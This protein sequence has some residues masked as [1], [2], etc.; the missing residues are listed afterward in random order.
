M[1]SA[2]QVFCSSVTA[3]KSGVNFYHSLQGR[4]SAAGET[5]SRAS[6]IRE[7]AEQRNLRASWEP[8]CL[9]PRLVEVIPYRIPQSI[10]RSL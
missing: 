2:L 9:R 5:P 6:L 1:A 10:A 4:L 7:C 3:A 8:A